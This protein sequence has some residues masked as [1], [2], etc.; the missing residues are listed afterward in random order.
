M[1]RIPNLKRRMIARN[2]R[3]KKVLRL[4]SVLFPY[5]SNIVS[6]NKNFVIK[7]KNITEIVVIVYIIVVYV[8]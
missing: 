3:T 1:R 2:Q 4:L 7:I 5:H 8:T 6:T